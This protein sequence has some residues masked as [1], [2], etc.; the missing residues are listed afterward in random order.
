MKHHIE[1]LLILASFFFSGLLCMC[2][3]GLIMVQ[4][5]NR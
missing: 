2:V 4:M 3:V 5:L 1:S